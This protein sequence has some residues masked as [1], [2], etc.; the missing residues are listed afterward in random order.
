MAVSPDYRAY[1]EELFE[2][3]AGAR[4]KRMFSGLGVFRDDVMFA[5]VADDRLYFKTDAETEP[6]FKEAGSEPFVYGSKS[7][8]IRMSYWTAP[9]EALDD[10]EL[11]QDWAR[12]GLEA[13]RR[14]AAAKP[15]RKRK[16]RAG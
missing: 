10:P 15:K 16:P 1:L 12:L 9:D 8:P 5:L 4:F 13:A 2:P 3:I 7:K 14:K 6:R 11:F